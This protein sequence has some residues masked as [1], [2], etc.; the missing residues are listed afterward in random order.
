[1]S[2]LNGLKTVQMMTQVWTIAYQP[3][4]CTNAACP[5]AKVSWPSASWQ[6]IAP[7]YSIYGYD[8]IAQIGWERQKGRM[9]FGRI[10]AGLSGRIQISASQVRY[11]YH[12]RYLPLLACHERQHLKELEELGHQSGL[13]LGLDGL[14]PEG[15]EPQLWVIRELQTGWTLRSG[16]MNSQDETAFVEF[17]QPIAALQLPVKAIMSDKQRALL[18]AVKQVFPDA[19]HGFCQ[20][21]YLNNAAEPVA[22]ADEQMKIELR[23]SVRAEVGDVIRQKQAEKPNLPVVTGMIPSPVPSVPTQ[24]TPLEPDAAAERERE[25]IVQD[26]LARTRYLLTLKGHP[27]FR[28]AGIEMFI[29]MRELANGLQELMKHQSEPRLLKLLSGLEK[30]LAATHPTYLELSQAASWLADLANILDPD[31]KPARTGEQVQAEWMS[32]LTRI[33]TQEHNSP[34]L[35]GFCTKIG[36]VSRSYASGL[37]HTYNIPGLPR[38]NNGRESEFRTLRHRLLSTTGQSG[39]TKRLLLREGAWELIPGPGSLLETTAAISHV[40]YDQFLQERQRV[41]I[42]RTPFRL[43]TRSARLSEI[44]LKKLLQRWMALPAPPVS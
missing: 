24:A 29:R 27:P 8:V 43:H 19:W 23:Q 25:G 16:W 18:P 28:L 4:R 6:R 12:Q 22:E 21:H 34:R 31:G 5:S 37:F 13:L 20:F 26:I 32:C 7:K 41:R 33:E 10:Y 9:D 3:K 30:A 15:G 17:M 2:Y 38:T 36:K 14:M 42:H 11:L 1:M 39:A 35:Q 40:E 44:Q